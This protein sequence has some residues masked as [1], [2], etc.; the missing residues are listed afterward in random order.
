M[1]IHERL[2]HLE[3]GPVEM[4]FTGPALK[5]GTEKVISVDSEIN[6]IPGPR[7]PQATRS[8]KVARVDDNNQITIGVVSRVL[9]SNN[10]TQGIKVATLRKSEINEKSGQL[11][12]RG[13]L[14]WRE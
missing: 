14:I 7:R 8:M 5:P 12:T 11:H 9:F 6:F 10:E 1:T 2:F 3:I 4:N 13:K